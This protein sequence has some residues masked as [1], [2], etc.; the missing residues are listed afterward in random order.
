MKTWGREVKVKTLDDLESEWASNVA[1]MRNISNIVSVVVMLSGICTI[2]AAANFGAAF[3][4][5][6]VAQLFF[7]AFVGMAGHCLASI[8]EQGTY[9]ITEESRCQP[10]TRRSFE[11]VSRE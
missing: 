4:A 1:S 10:G 9:R 2:F 7:A 8:V 3:F 5:A 11:S 6:G